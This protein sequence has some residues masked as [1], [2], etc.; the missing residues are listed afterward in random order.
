MDLAIVLII[1]V[2]GFAGWQY[3]EK[4][5]IMADLKHYRKRSKILTRK[6]LRQQRRINEL[7]DRLSY[8]EFEASM[9]SDH[10]MYM[11]EQLTELNEN[12]QALKQLNKAMMPPI[13]QRDKK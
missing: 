7:N 4:Q 9:Y 12:Y 2:A 1:V 11:N 10:S 8:S 5:Y 3:L 13:P 6:L